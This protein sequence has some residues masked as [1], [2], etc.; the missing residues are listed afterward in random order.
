MKGLCFFFHDPFRFRVDFEAEAGRK[1]GGPE[2]TQCVFLKAF[3][4]SPHAADQ[5]PFQVLLPAE[6]VDEA[7][8]VI[9]GHGVDGEVP[10]L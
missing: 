5:A 2:Y 3:L 7:G 9:I 10:A 1:A 8:L 4:R 6:D